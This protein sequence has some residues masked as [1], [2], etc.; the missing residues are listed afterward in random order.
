MM[1]RVERFRSQSSQ[2]SISINLI[3]PVEGE[4]GFDLSMIDMVFLDFVGAREIKRG[5]DMLDIVKAR[6]VAVR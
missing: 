6:C 1:W 3:K 2:S 5:F 4:I